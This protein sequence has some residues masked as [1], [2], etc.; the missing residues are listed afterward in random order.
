MFRNEF[1]FR[2]STLHIGNTYS[3][4]H[5]HFEVRTIHGFL[6]QS[7]VIS[8]FSGSPVFLDPS[9]IFPNASP[10]TLG[11]SPPPLL[12][13]IVAE[14]KLTRLETSQGP[15]FSFSGLIVNFDVSP[16][17]DTINLIH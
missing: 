2:F 10:E 5:G 11:Q 15:Q 16:I 3:S 12:L 1:F 7:N 8:G 17:V 4:I 14:E 6:T 13:G 9:S